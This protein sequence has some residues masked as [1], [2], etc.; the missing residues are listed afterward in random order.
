LESNP[1]RP[2]HALFL[3]GLSYLGL[4][5]FVY[6]FNFAV[7]FELNRSFSWHSW[8]KQQ[9]LRHLACTR[10][11]F[12]SLTCRSDGRALRG[13]MSRLSQHQA[14]LCP[15]AFCRHKIRTCRAAERPVKHHKPFNV[16]FHILRSL[17]S[18]RKEVAKRAFRFTVS[19][20]SHVTPLEPKNRFLPGS[21]TTI[22]RNIATSVKI[23]WE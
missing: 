18:D 3:S 16:E 22:C 23:G 2:V 7:S 6:N 9:D 11:T 10:V 5:P 4:R 8:I 1:W 19:V 20:C 12:E 13:V 15:S 21:F 17:Y 14:H